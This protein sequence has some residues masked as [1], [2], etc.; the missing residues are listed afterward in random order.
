MSDNSLPVSVA[1][2][3]DEA[4][5]T[6]PE[7]DVTANTESADQ[8]PGDAETP[9]P[10]TFTQEEL[11]KIVAKEKAKVERQLRR[12]MTQQA[13]EPQ[14]PT[15]GEPPDPKDFTDPLSY[16]KA[17]AKHIAAE[18]I[19]EREA[20]QHQQTVIKT[21]AERE[22]AARDKYTDFQEVV[23]RDDLPISELMA[24]V[25]R[26]SEVGPEVAYHLGKHP[27][28]AA[29]I[30]ALSPLQQAKEIGRLEAALSSNPVPVKKASSAPDPI[31]P[32]NSRGTTPTYDP[33]DPRSVKSMSDSEWI[34][35]RNE[36]E[37]KRRSS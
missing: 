25:I 8:S 27:E 5:V 15:L 10:R 23:Y 35:A 1:S 12:E 30:Y 3:T 20:H 21:Y 36:Q 31:K 24:E 11:D 9:E 4:V 28:E 14:V 26:E 32:L 33:A 37:A 18:T 22:E 7:S 29:R 6:A 13:H 16:A 2:V 17:L 19:A 34:R